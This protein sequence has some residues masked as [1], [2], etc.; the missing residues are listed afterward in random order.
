MEENKIII[1]REL[2]IEDIKNNCDQKVG[3][4]EY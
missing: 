1:Q 2:S 4:Y 3:S